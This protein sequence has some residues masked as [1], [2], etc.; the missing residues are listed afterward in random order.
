MAFEGD[1]KDFGL[2]EI[3]QLISVQQKSGMLLVNCEEKM[4]IFFRDGMLI[5][6][7]DRRDR[8]RD[9]LKD[10]LLRYG[11]LSR[12]EMNSLQQIQTE[13]KLDLTEIMLSEK[14]FS[15]DFL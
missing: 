12:S 9:P 7:R 13:T 2:S 15:E 4:A 8:T 6:T 11:F 1:V 3:L 14:Y 10:Y 5:S